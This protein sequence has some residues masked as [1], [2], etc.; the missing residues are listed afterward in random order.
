LAS[1]PIWRPCKKDTEW[2]LPRFPQRLDELVGTKTLNTLGK[3]DS[4]KRLEY[5]VMGGSPSR[6]SSSNPLSSSGI[7]RATRKNIAHRGP[8][9]G[10]IGQQLG[11][12][13]S[14]KRRVSHFRR[15]EL[16]K[17]TP[18]CASYRLRPREV[19]VYR[20]TATVVEQSAFLRQDTGIAFGSGRFCRRV[21]F[22]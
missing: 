7:R 22:P 21:R 11:A 13:P 5:N 20:R 17:S 4:P 8:H 10:C 9:P 16:R 3:R 19:W 15:Q 14:P 1:S 2:A 18:K 12:H 6:Q